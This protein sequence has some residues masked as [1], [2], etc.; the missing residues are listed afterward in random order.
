MSLKEEGLFL[1]MEKYNYNTHSF[2]VQLATEIGLEECLLLQH[3][4]YW[5][6]LNAENEDM[7]KDGNVWFFTSRR[8]ILTIFPYL[9]EQKI[10]TCVAKLLEGGYIVKGNY[11]SNKMLK[12]N[13]YALTP[14]SIE[15]FGENS[16]PLANSTDDWLKQP[17][18]DSNIYNNNIY[19]KKE[20]NIFDIIKEKE[21]SLPNS[22]SEQNAPVA[23]DHTNS[24]PLTTEKTKGVGLPTHL[25]ANPLPTREDREQSFRIKAYAYVDTYGQ[26]MINDFCDYWTEFGGKKMR[27]EK[28]KTWELSRRLQ[29]WKRNEDERAQ[30]YQR[31]YPQPQQQEY[32][33]NTA[34]SAKDFIAEYEKKHR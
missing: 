27:F 33:T 10:K 2:S 8:N 29:T 12:T 24:N 21:F 19:N 3:F 28:E 34:K 5:H 17:T 1:E 25:T 23:C 16:R 11:N 13:W 6:K 31:R 18:K 14:K 32:N 7:F 20:T 22:T 26:K 9:T 30:R 15:L 4:F